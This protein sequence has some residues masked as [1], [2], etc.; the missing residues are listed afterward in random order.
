[1]HRERERERER[2]GQ[3]DKGVAVEAGEVEVWGSVKTNRVSVCSFFCQFL[4]ESVLFS[5]LLFD[6]SPSRL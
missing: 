5:L 6:T 2:E 3:S 1:V 4:N